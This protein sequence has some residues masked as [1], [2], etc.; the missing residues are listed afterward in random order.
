[1][2]LEPR[3]PQVV[4]IAKYRIELV[5]HAV[6]WEFYGIRM[7]EL[8]NMLWFLEQRFYQLK[9][10]YQQRIAEGG[11]PLEPSM[12]VKLMDLITLSIGYFNIA[13]QNDTPLPQPPIGGELAVQIGAG[14]FLIVSVFAGGEIP[15]CGFGESSYN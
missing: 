7:T 2:Y 12:E 14:V 11:D 6:G 3:E 15:T 9:E 1:M 10:I 5:N 13:I 8:S 4:P